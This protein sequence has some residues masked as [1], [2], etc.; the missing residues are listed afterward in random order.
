MMDNIKQSEGKEELLRQKKE[1]LIAAIQSSDNEY[2][3]QSTL[4]YMLSLKRALGKK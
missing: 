3:V 4:T 1:I 2:L